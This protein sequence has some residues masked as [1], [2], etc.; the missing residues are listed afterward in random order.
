MKT[1]RLTCDND[2]RS[3]FHEAA[4][5]GICDFD[6]VRISDLA[7]R[8]PADRYNSFRYG[9]GGYAIR[10]SEGKY[11]SYGTGGADH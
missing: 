7:C 2:E 3:G 4:K 10:R 9:G 6:N 8:M 11:N 1:K 5:N